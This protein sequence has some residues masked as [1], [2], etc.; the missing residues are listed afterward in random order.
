MT[1]KKI[2]IKKI[3]KVRRENFTKKIKLKKG[4][5]VIVTS[6]SHN[7]AKGVI[8]KIIRKTNQV[9][10]QN[11]NVKLK[12]RRPSMEDMRKYAKV[13]YPI[14]ISN[15]MISDPKLLIPTKIGYKFIEI[16]PKKDKNPAVLKKVRY[17]KK[18]G[19]LIDAV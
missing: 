17:A 1:S 5:D 4:D 10:V 14:N 3:A 6:G 15:V 7:G 2:K 8:L 11:V 12:K 9:I 18:S 19:E 13:E 16:T